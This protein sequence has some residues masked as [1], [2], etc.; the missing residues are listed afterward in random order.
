M[1]ETRDRLLLAELGPILDGRSSTVLRH[2]PDEAGR[3]LRRA[4]GHL[5]DA[6]QLALSAADSMGGCNTLAAIAAEGVLQMKQRPRI[7]YSASQRALL[8]E[9]WRRG[10][11]IHQIASLFDRY[12]SSVHRIR[13]ESGGICPAER[14]RSRLALR[15]LQVADLGSR[16]GNGSNR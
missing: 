10:E 2:T 14:H 1:A 15:T 7:Y 6:H 9:R 13:A 4:S 16:Q 5:A 8:W 11:T 12:H 3:P